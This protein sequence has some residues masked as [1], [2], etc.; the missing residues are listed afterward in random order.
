MVEKLKDNLLSIAIG[1]AMGVMSTVLIFYLTSLPF[2]PE[3]VKKHFI[4][5]ISEKLE[6]MESSRFQN[7]YVDRYLYQEVDLGSDKTVFLLG[8]AESNDK[9]YR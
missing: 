1:L 4:E 2:T 8:T 3:E 6:V 5:I 9:I 7:I